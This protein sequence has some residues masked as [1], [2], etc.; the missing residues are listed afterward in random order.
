MEAISF[1]YELY[2]IILI[3]LVAI[4][5]VAL[6]TEKVPEKSLWLRYILDTHE[7]GLL[8]RAYV[9]SKD[10]YLFI[11]SVWNTMFDYF[12]LNLHVC[13]LARVGRASQVETRWMFWNANQ[14]WVTWHD[15]INKWA[16]VSNSSSTSGRNNKLC[17]L[18]SS[19]QVKSSPFASLLLIQMSLV[20]WNYLLDFS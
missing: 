8:V 9:S 13:T 17:C 11:S 4:T 10:Q 18:H 3:T 5:Y 1:E 14:C 15:S 16:S 20:G 12:T 7:I 6:E 2:N 19:D